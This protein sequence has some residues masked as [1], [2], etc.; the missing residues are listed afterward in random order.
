MLQSEIVVQLPSAPLIHLGGDK[1]LGLLET[2][3]VISVPSFPSLAI[4]K[5]A[6]VYLPESL[7]LAVFA[8]SVTISVPLENANIVLDPKVIS[9]RSR[10]SPAANPETVPVKLGAASNLRV[11]G[12]L[13]PGV[14]TKPCTVLLLSE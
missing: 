1:E 8:P 5:L 9:V 13:P 6:A 11:E 12:I 2:E 4:E 10:K 14:A 7:M 3:V